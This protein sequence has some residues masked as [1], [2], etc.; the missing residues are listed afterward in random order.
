MKSE[1]FM[2]KSYLAAVIAATS[3]VA[4]SEVQSEE[5]NV[6]RVRRQEHRAVRFLADNRDRPTLYDRMQRQRRDPRY[7]VDPYQRQRSYRR[8]YDYRETTPYRERAPQ[9]EVEENSQNRKESLPNYYGRDPY[10][11]TS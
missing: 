1:A 8:S 3:F 7:Q 10:K 2:W 11:V 6:R 9:R 4:I 5:V